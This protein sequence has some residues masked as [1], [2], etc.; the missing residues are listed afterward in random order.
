MHIEAS[1]T[2]PLSLDLQDVSIRS[3]T[4]VSPLFVVRY[5]GLPVQALV[6]LRNENMT[7]LASSII[8]LDNRIGILR[9]QLSGPLHLAVHLAALAPKPSDDAA[10]V[11]DMKRAVFNNRPPKNIDR[12][13]CA[14]IYLDVESSQLLHMWNACINARIALES[15]MEKVGQ[16]DLIDSRRQLAE[17]LREP[18]FRKALQIASPLLEEQL[19]K[20]LTA[21]PN[22]LNHKLRL[23]E[24]STIL[25][26]KRAAIKTSPFSTFGIVAPGLWDGNAQSSLVAARNKVIT[27]SR[28]NV[29][30]LSRLVEEKLTTFTITKDVIVTLNPTCKRVDDSV[31]F[32]R[33]RTRA[34]KRVGATGALHSHGVFSMAITPMIETIMRVLDEVHT[35]SLRTLE[36]H[37][38]TKHADLMLNVGAVTSYLLRCSL[39]LVSQP[40]DK[41]DYE[42]LLAFIDSTSAAHSVMKPLQAELN[43][44]SGSNLVERRNLLGNIKTR[45]RSL[46]SGG[47]DDV[48]HQEGSFLYEDA[49]FGDECMTLNPMSNA[50]LLRRLALL[51]HILPLFDAGLPL[52]VGLNEYFKKRYGL[53]GRCDNLSELAE[54]FARECSEPFW[55]RSASTDSRNLIDQ[56][57]SVAGT[58]VS[59]L[60]RMLTRRD[61]IKRHLVREA[62]RPETAVIQIDENMLSNVAVSV[63]RSL[64]KLLSSSFFMQPTDNTDH[65]Q[66]VLNK[67]YGGLGQMTSRFLYLWKDYKH[68]SPSG[69]LRDYIRS[70]QPSGTIFAEMRGGYDTNLNLHE[71]LTEYEIVFPAEFSS[72]QA[73]YQI[74]LSDLVITHIQQRDCL[75][76]R[77][78]ATGKEVIP[79]YLGSLVTMMLPDVHRLLLTFAPSISASLPSW[80]TLLAHEEIAETRRFPRVITGDVVLQRG[81][82]AIPPHRKPVRNA[83]DSDAKYFLGVRRWVADHNLPESFFAYLAPPLG[84]GTRGPDADQHKPLF[85]DTNSLLSLLVFQ[86]ELVKHT[87]MLWIAELLP[88]YVGDR[89][90][91]SAD[92]QPFAP[93]E[94]VF[95]VTT[96]FA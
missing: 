81:M 89:T 71:G 83:A 36:D 84:T 42:S 47:L 52:R 6:A 7:T 66:W 19:D 90:Q 28:I 38:V 1:K 68:V 46:H 77:S 55:A 25:Y 23:I 56:S 37:V 86:K 75:E 14:E 60:R 22:R 94:C 95:D 44:L 12:V 29:A 48:V 5:P 91:E 74:P 88:D 41:A 4:T 39:L 45:I 50:K 67:T 3:A 33:Q 18:D 27:Q 21:D 72:K 11:L 16:E 30:L 54:S 65:P 59:E 53:G 40:Y 31:Q 32:L 85:V 96:E 69:L 63:P 64:Y 8:A 57:I 35:C 17:W 10:L 49:T 51:Q 15:Q 76:L 70:S 43:L 62:R 24:S 13:A 78:L 61:M 2:F 82:W 34:L 87:H 9:D 58:R 92:W 93:C 20:Y 79:L 80:Q 73:E 26:F